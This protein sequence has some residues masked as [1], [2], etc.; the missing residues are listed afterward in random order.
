M[1]FPITFSIPEE[2]ICNT[3][4]EKTKILSSLIPG[5]VRTYIYKNEEDYY[6]EYKTS[7]FAITKLKGGWDCLRHY[8]IMANGCI[9]HFIDIEK[10]PKNTLALLPKDLFIEASKLF[11]IFICK[12]INN[13]SQQEIR[14][15]NVL[16]TKIWDY[17][18]TYLTTDK[19]AKYVLQKIHKENTKKIL[20]LSGDLD[21]DYLRC[22]T[23]HGFKTIFGSD[24][25]DYPKVPHIYKSENINFS[26]LYGKGMSYTNLLDPIL[27][28]EQLDSSII[29]DIQNKHY[30]IIIYGSY[31]R[32]MPHYE[33]VCQVYKPN[34]IILLCGQD[35][36]YCDKSENN[37]VKKGHFVFVREL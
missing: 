37:Y 9:P 21:P 12:N 20:Y 10:C 16:R 4:N 8:E 27:H 6:N 30:D 7:Y 14:E 35:P 34:E 11:N 3:Y 5:D 2:K 1:L 32:G 25:H 19:V 24:C 22:L 23:L 33:L 13:L 29:E 36:C 26:I 28:N 15:Y 18:K 17:T 31:H